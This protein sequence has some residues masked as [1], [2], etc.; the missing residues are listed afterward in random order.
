MQHGFVFLTVCILT[1]SVFAQGPRSAEPQQSLTFDVVAIH[2]SRP[3]VTSGMVKPLPNGAGYTVQNMTAKIMMS[4]MY[5]IPE[6]QIEG[7]PG[8]FGADRFD[9]E[10]RADRGG[11]SIDE[12]HAM[13]KNLLKDRFGLKIHVDT[14]EG[15]VYILT[16]DKGGS[17]M[18]DDGSES[19]LNIPMLPG[20]P[21]Q[22]VGTKVPMEYLCWFLGQI[23]PNDMRPVIDQTGLKDFYDFTLRFAPELPAGVSSD[24]LPPELRELP[25]LR[26]AVQEQLGLVLKPAKGPVEYYV[27]DHVD[28]P[29]AN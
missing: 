14:R 10:A 12:L 22:W 13:F 28:R 1:T 9:I 24:S 4:V 18:K 3:G 6:R 23:S 29:S 25:V 15:P 20:G 2:P 27:I 7:G 16:V 8:W 11:Y 19:G 17:K 26:D 21:G 5:R